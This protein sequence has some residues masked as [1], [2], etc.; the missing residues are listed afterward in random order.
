MLLG[1][2]QLLVIR[3][4]DYWSLFIFLL[5]KELFDEFVLG[6]KQEESPFFDQFNVLVVKMSDCGLKVGGFLVL[7]DQELKLVFLIGGDLFLDEVVPKL[8][9]FE[10]TL[11]KKILDKSIS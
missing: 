3:D 4:S 11:H 7:G 8:R 5:D 1:S 9:P 10:V 6:N 2:L